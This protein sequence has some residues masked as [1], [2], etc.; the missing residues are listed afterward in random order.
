[1]PAYVLHLFAKQTADIGEVLDAVE[2]AFAAVRAER[3][4][5]I[6]RWTCWRGPGDREFGAMLEL[7]EGQH[8]PFAN[9]EAVKRMEAVVAESAVAPPTA[10]LVELLGTYASSS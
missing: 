1:M 6:Q 2:A 8:N 5:A 10:K 3:P 4:R 9:I 7:V